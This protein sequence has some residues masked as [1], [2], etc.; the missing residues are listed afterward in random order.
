MKMHMKKYTVYSMALTLVVA[1]GCE[2]FLSKT[3]DNR[4]SLD[5]KEKLAELLV[6]AYPEVNYIAF[7]EAMSDNVEDNPSG[8]KDPANTDPYFWRDG[9][10]T[11]QDT[12]ENYW[13]GCYAAIAASNHAL[14]LIANTG[15]PADLASQK[16]EA[17]V[18]R[19]YNHFMLVTLFA[20][21]Y[22][23]TGIDAV[24]PGV[25]YVTDPEKQSF[26]EYDR[27]TVKSVYDQ[28]EK[29]LTEGLPLINDQAYA[30][31][32]EGTGVPK[33]HFT[34]AA[35]HAFA[36]RFYL[37]KHDYDKVIEHAN[38]VFPEGDFYTRLRPWNTTYSSYTGAELSLNYTKSTEAANLLLCETSSLWARS[39]NAYRYSTGATKFIEMMNTNP[40]GQH[41][42][43]NG[44]YS[45]S[46]VYFVYK[47]KE[48]FVQ[49]GTNSTTGFPYAI[50]P[51]LTAEEVLFNR[52]EA[53]VMQNNFTASLNDLNTWISTRVVNYVS[54]D[55]LWM[56]KLFDYYPDKKTSRDVVLAAILD[57]KR[58]EFVHEGQ[59]WFDILRHNIEV[60]HNVKG[61]EPIV[62]KAGDK[63]RVLQIPREAISTGGLS[64]NPR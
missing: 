12:P 54:T 13:N 51:L 21:T 5:S 4:A 64:P 48:H 58:I 36:T 60:T 57:F 50:V 33:Y 28:I 39:F 62:L 26:K 59:R 22:T 14:E 55:G 45:S 61:E 25:P 40:S 47:F 44:F 9:T 7:C 46:G 18:T 2:D 37:F 35:A 24:N 1:M 19:A 11:D 20:Q 52:A 56:E 34:Q 27:G 31:G 6:T 17:L 32:T 3:P 38:A 63:R 53:Y 23:A 41:Y 8:A 43:F 30:S 10:T 29:D 15:D 16:G 49:T 42:A